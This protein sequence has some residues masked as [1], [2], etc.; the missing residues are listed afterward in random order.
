MWLGILRMKWQVKNTSIR[1]KDE[2]EKSSLVEIIIVI[3]SAVIS[4][5]VVVALI[6]F[7]SNYNVDISNNIETVNEMKNTYVLAERELVGRTFTDD[8]VSL[9]FEGKNQDEILTKLNLSSLNNFI[10]SGGKV[11]VD[12][13]GKAI[14]TY[15]FNIKLKKNGLTCSTE[16]NTDQYIYEDDMMQCYSFSSILGGIKGIFGGLRRTDESSMSIDSS[17]DENAV[18]NATGRVNG[19]YIE[20]PLYK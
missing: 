6:S 15:D 14:D 8:E 2:V 12:M 9:M 5:F 18:D 3:V 19:I 20:Y 13:N 16:V 10:A 1:L 17:Y 7:I 11:D 4:L